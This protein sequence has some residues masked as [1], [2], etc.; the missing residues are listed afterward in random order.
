MLVK[1]RKVLDNARSVLS[2]LFPR[3]PLDSVETVLQHGYSKGSGRVGRS[4]ILSEDQKVT[5]A[6][7]A[8]IRHTKT[9]YDRLLRQGRATKDT[10]NHRD[11]CRALVRAQIDEILKDWRPANWYRKSAKTASSGS[12]VMKH[13]PGLSKRLIRRGLEDTHQESDESDEDVSQGDSSAQRSNAAMNASVC[14]TKHPREWDRKSDAPHACSITKR[15]HRDLVASKTADMK[16][17]RRKFINLPQI[18]SQNSN[19]EIIISETSTKPIIKNHQTK[20]R[21]DDSDAKTARSATPKISKRKISRSKTQIRIVRPLHDPLL[22]SDEEECFLQSLKTVDSRGHAA[23]VSPPK[24]SESSV[25]RD[26]FARKLSYA[27]QV[28]IQ[29]L[30]G[31]LSDEDMMDLD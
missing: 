14:A 9:P 12:R 31:N 28:H 17:E 30:S 24:E 20:K 11:N 8:H 18:Q 10:G 26:V 13:S 3:M 2:K 21:S 15:L 4:T 22:T 1:D 7:I 5:A 19:N 25:L 23:S 29:D 27:A 6:V 16:L